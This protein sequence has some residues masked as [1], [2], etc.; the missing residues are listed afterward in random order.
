VPMEMINIGF[1]NC[2]ATSRIIAVARADSSPLKRLVENAGAE[3]RLI[4]ATSGR[5]TRSVIVTDS[6]H[7]VLSH[8]SPATIRDKL[9]GKTE[10]TADDD[11]TWRPR[12]TQRSA[13]SQSSKGGPQRD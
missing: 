3:N 6:H 7:V 5:K 13:A 2:L 1:G 10:A 9:T 4:D 8:Q 11:D 12:A